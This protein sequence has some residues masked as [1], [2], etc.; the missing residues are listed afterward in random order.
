M[1]QELVALNEYLNSAQKTKQEDKLAKLTHEITTLR[2]SIE[3]LDTST[4]QLAQM[5]DVLSVRK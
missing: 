5:V 4:R 1:A 3:T 2:A